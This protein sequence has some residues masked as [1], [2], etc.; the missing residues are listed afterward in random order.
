MRR[1]DDEAER[2]RDDAERHFQQATA[3]HVSASKLRANNNQK[4]LS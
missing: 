2:E 4:L 3:N 1:R